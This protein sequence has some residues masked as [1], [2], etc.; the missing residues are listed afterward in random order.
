MSYGLYDVMTL[1]IWD[2]NEII[3]FTKTT[4]VTGITVTELGYSMKYK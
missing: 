3:V 1:D 4:V 2:T